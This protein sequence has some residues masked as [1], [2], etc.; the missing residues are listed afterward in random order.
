MQ[1]DKR[2]TY[3]RKVKE[4]KA[5]SAPKD[6]EEGDTTIEDETIEGANGAATNGHANGDDADRP[7]KKLK[8]DDGAAVAPDVDMEDEDDAGDEGQEDDQDEPDDGDD[9]HDG[10]DDEESD[11]DEQDRSLEEIDEPHTTA[12]DLM[13]V[14][15]ALDDPGS[16]SD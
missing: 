11:G 13:P 7:T 1:C 9:V 8:G 4:D 15:E 16:D 2:N 6:G 5:A 3:R 10:D 12:A 14:D